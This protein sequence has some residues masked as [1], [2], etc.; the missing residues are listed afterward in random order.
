MRRVSIIGLVGLTGLIGLIGLQAQPYGACAPETA[1]DQLITVVRVIIGD[2]A[3]MQGDLYLHRGIDGND[4]AE[5]Y[6]M[7]K[8]YNPYALF[9]HEQHA[10][11]AC[12]RK[13]DA[14]HDAPDVHMPR[15]DE[16]QLLPLFWLT[17]KA[18]PHNI[19]NWSVGSYWLTR[20]G[21]PRAARA[22]LEQGLQHNP[23]SAVLALD[24]GVLL[25]STGGERGT[26]R[27]T[28]LLWRALGGVQPPQERR[29]AYTYLGAALRTM[30]AA[31]AL[32][33]LRLHWAA[34]FPVAE[35]PTPLYQP[36]PDAL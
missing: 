21:N 17:A 6:T 5:Q 18:D 35:M 30:Q 33:D 25:F 29:R 36:L 13:H 10:D 12:G 31:R 7:F 28:N 27:I 3:W 24:L 23:A 26:D 34:E 8:P 32:A 15:N 9:R 22:F 19:Q 16:A 20:V 4:H 1:W 11:E 14:E 2:A